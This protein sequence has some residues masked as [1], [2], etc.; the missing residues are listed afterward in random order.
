MYLNSSCYYI[1]T[2]LNLYHMSGET[3]LDSYIAA[4][5]TRPAGATPTPRQK[6]KEVFGSRFKSDLEP[7]D[8]N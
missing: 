7:S 8:Q 3:R 1:N 6:V 2:L 5:Y 4:K